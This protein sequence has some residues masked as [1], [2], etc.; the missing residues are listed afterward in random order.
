MA[1][2]VHGGAGAAHAMPGQAAPPAD[3]LWPT[4]GKAGAGARQAGAAKADKL[5][6]GRQGPLRRGTKAVCRRMLIVNREYHYNRET[7]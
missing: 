6:A 4:A 7:R 1:E 5:C 2:K 3:R